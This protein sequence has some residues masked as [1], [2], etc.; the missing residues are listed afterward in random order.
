MFALLHP[1]VKFTFKKQ[2]ITQPLKMLIAF[3]GNPWGGAP[4]VADDDVLDVR[5]G[6]V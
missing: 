4:Q 6:Q 3:L 5:L 1:R 2:A